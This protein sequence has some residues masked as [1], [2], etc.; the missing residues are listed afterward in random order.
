MNLVTGR[1]HPIQNGGPPFHGDALE[2]GKHGQPDVV[3][4]RDPVVGTFPLL[5]ARRR[6]GLAKKRPVRF[7]AVARVRV[8]IARR[9]VG[10]LVFHFLQIVQP[11]ANDGA[12]KLKKKNTHTER[13]TSEFLSAR[14]K[15]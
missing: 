9:R 2:H 13:R 1:T 4:R 3:E 6:I 5:Y 12:E 14:K 7:R 8:R 11:V 15:A 10:S